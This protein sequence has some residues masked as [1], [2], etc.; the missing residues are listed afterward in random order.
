MITPDTLHE[1][2]RRIGINEGDRLTPYQDTMGFWTVGKGYNLQ[3]ADRDEVCA[4]L[5]AAGCPNPNAVLDEHASITQ[6]VSDKLFDRILPSYIQAASAS[7][8]T[9]IFY[10]LAPARQ[11]VVVDLE[12]NLGQRGWLGFVNTRAAI[13]KAQGLKNSGDDTGAHNWFGV[14]ANALAESLWARQVGNRALRDEAM[15]RTSLFCSPYG[16]GSD[17][18]GG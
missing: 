3:K 18:L 17:I 4:D 5:A 11:V 9:G 1:I 10:S 13:A 8:P 2:V 15:M 12:Y 14:V 16:D 7:L 6:D